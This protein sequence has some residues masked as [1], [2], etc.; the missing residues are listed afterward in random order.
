MVLDA[1]DNVIHFLWL[2]FLSVVLPSG[3]CWT[4]GC[5]LLAIGVYV[6][7]ERWRSHKDTKRRKT[8]RK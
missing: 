3:A 8:D 1:I 6:L 5:T 7:I 2:W 4:F